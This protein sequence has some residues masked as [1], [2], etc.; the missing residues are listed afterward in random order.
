MT[1][2]LVTV[3]RRSGPRNSKTD[4]ETG[5]RY[6]TWQGRDLP[7]VTTV[8][9]LAGIP[10]RLHEWA[11]SQVVDRAI[12][13]IGTYYGQLSTG[14]PAQ[15]K[16]VRHE[17]RVAATEERDKAAA[18]GSAVHSAIEAGKPLTE[19]GAD[20]APKVRMELD[21]RERSGVEILAREI[22]VWNLAVGYAGSVDLLAR[23]PDGSIWVIDN[24]TGSGVYADHLLQLLPYLMAEFVGED[25]VV[26]E[27]LTALLRQ[28]TGIALLHLEDDAWEFRSL[29]ATP[30][31]WA[32][33]RGLLSFAMWQAS[34][35]EVDDVTLATRKVKR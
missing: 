26:D 9:R 1:A 5:I 15:V 16:V 29:R 4:P 14:D 18:L 21:W 34:H 12:E 11:I 13:R 32:A 10:F 19:V 30:E 24:K 3:G 8:R 28:A 33:F 35:T 17:L 2:P 25:D 22:Q 27:R 6:Y 7:S 23:F 31:A 20:V